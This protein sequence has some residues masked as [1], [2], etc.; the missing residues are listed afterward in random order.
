MEKICGIYKIT[1]L[2]N[3]HCYIGQS[4]NIINRWKDHQI[5]AHNPDNNCYNYPLYRAFRKYGLE[6]FQFE[7]IEKCSMDILNERE[8][9][10]I[11]HYNPEYNQTIGKEYNIVPQKLTYEQV[12]EIQQIL[13]KDVEGKISHKELGERFGVSGRD[14]IRD[15]NNGRTWYNS[16][17]NYPLH[18]THTDN[19][20]KPEYKCKKCGCLIKTNSN[21]CRECS[22]I[23]QRR[24]ERPTREEL[25]QLIRTTAFTAIGKKFNV[26]DKTIC[27][28]CIYYNLP[29]KKKDIKLYTDEEWDNL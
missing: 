5:T 15:I 29:S 28:W 6:N 17:L 22:Y 25:K 1:N 23:L 24:T 8:Q 12:Q 10:W 14:T 7:I 13:I 18:I 4:R 26:S 9:Y 11:K 27:K 20:Y 3:Q 21:Y 2:Q 16:D 19:R